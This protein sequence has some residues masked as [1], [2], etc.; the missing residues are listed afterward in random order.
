VTVEA[1][2]ARPATRLVAWPAGRR[3]PM[4]V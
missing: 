3:P 1:P 4:N 2:R